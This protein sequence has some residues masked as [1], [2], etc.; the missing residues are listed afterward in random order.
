[1]SDGATQDPLPFNS[2]TAA[3]KEY[4]C[5][6]FGDYPLPV[7]YIRQTVPSS[8]IYTN[9]VLCDR[10]LLLDT[11]FWSRG[12]V[13]LVGDVAHAYCPALGQ[14]GKVAL[15]DMP[16][17]TG[18]SIIAK[19]CMLDTSMSTPEAL[20]KEFGVNEKRPCPTNLQCFQRTNPEQK[21]TEGGSTR[22]T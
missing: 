18:W 19:L 16:V 2:P 22:Y 14:G 1:M 10:D 6:L 12:P 3:T 11:P 4:L 21:R 15:E 5:D 20:Q 9:R 17:K 13:V 8:A 7:Q